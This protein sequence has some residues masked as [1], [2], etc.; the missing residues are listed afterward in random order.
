MCSVMYPGFFKTVFY[1]SLNIKKI[2][3]WLLGDTCKYLGCR[4]E[5]RYQVF[6]I[7]SYGKSVFLEKGYRYFGILQPHVPPFPRKCGIA[8]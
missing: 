4:K 1:R 5:F 8:C 7:K 2:W 6:W 3:L